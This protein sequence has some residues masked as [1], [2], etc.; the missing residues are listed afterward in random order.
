[1]R[2]LTYSPAAQRA[3]WTACTQEPI[4]GIEQFTFPI[5][6]TATGFLAFILLEVNRHASTLAVRNEAGY[7]CALCS[8]EKTNML[9]R[10]GCLPFL[11]S[12][13][14]HLFQRIKAQEADAAQGSRPPHYTN[15]T[16]L[17]HILLVNTKCDITSQPCLCLFSCATSFSVLSVHQYLR[18]LPQPGIL[19]G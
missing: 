19:P 16:L 13:V 3:T 4:L 1:M 12:I 9:S 17:S 2:R 14:S 6:P 18:L 11:V 15:T 5:K 8:W 10:F 7:P